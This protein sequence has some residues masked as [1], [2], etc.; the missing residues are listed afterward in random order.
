[1]EVIST[2]LKKGFHFSKKKKKTHIAIFK[3]LLLTNIRK[4][5]QVLKMF[6]HQK[7]KH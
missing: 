6:K 5:L 1:M 2:L 4:Y 3:H 7:I